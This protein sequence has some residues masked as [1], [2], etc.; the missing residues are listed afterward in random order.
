M[1]NGH[2]FNEIENNLYSDNEEKEEEEFNSNH[3]NNQKKRKMKKDLFGYIIPNDSED[4]EER[5]ESNSNKDDSANISNDNSEKENEYS[6]Y[7]KD[8]DKETSKNPDNNSSDKHNNGYENNY[9]DDNNDLINDSI[10]G[11]KF[12]FNPNNQIPESPRFLKIITNNNN[13]NNNN[14]INNQNNNNMHNSINKDNQFKKKDD[15]EGRNNTTEDIDEILKKL[16]ISKPIVDDYNTNKKE[17]KNKESLKKEQIKTGKENNNNSIKKEI[18][19][20]KMD[21]KLRDISIHILNEYG[22]AGDS[23]I[24]LTEN[25]INTY[26]NM[27]KISSN[28]N[29]ITIKNN[30]DIFTKKK[31]SNKDS[32]KEYNKI[33]HS[34]NV[35]YKSPKNI[36]KN[37]FTENRITFTSNKKTIFKK[38]NNI[39]NYC[40]TNT[41]RK[42]RIKITP[43]L[44]RITRNLYTPK[45]CQK[46]HIDNY[47]FSPKINSKSQEI[48]NKKI[49]N[50]RPNT[51]IGD[52]LYAEAY[53]KRQ[54]QKLQL[55]MKEKNEK[56]NKM[57]MNKSTYN[58]AFIRIKKKI[59]NT[60]KKYSKN[61]KLSIVGFTQCLFDL[62]IITELIKKKDNKENVNDDLDIVKLQA[63][64][65][66]IKVNDK[67]KFNEVE[68]L[69]QLWFKINPSNNNYINSQLLSELLKILFSSNNKVNELMN[70]I[71]ALFKKSGIYINN[72]C[73]VVEYDKNNILYTSPLTNKIYNKN[74]FWSLTKIIKLFINIM[75]NIKA[76]KFNDYNKSKKYNEI[77]ENRDKDL[78]FKPELSNKKS[79]Y[80]YNKNNY[81]LSPK[82]KGDTKKR[83]NDFNDICEKLM[84]EKDIHTS[85]EKIRE[86]KPAKQLK[87]IKIC[88]NIPKINKSNSPNKNFNKK[89]KT[90][91]NDSDEFR[92]LIKSKSNINVNKPVYERSYNKRKKNNDHYNNTIKGIKY[93]GNDEIFN[94]SY[95]NLEKNKKLKQNDEY[96]KKNIDALKKKEF[97]K[98]FKEEKFYNNYNKNKKMNIKQ[99]NISKLKEQ[100]TPPKIKEKINKNEFINNIENENIFEDIF[101]TVNIKIPNGSSKPLKIYDKNYNDT[102]GYVNNF[103]RIY[104]INDEY[105]KIIFKKVMQYKNSFFNSRNKIENNK[106]GFVMNEDFDTIANTYNDSNPSNNSN[107]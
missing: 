75:Q 58:M 49:K 18:Y 26:T 53:M 10:G 12:S 85:L 61:G 23:Q 32:K 19:N 25:N 80:D 100:K 28:K 4:D 103:C 69:E 34:R 101:I 73:D 66:S 84:C 29:D 47:S 9:N 54:K 81:I 96:I 104:H 21:N 91:N 90:I 42:R 105:K 31:I 70:Y 24:S 107:P 92:F 102:L 16:R 87:I 71:E 38:E 1:S 5:E 33:P 2:N 17:I 14:E 106:D 27:G 52:I 88:T 82:N 39:T 83:K 57:K 7:Q 74:E 41:N 93:I 45:R 59:D 99:V 94:E 37:N 65:K 63:I 68:L 67:K 6:R 97:E 15:D 50:K 48:Y 40:Y 3:N 46:K 35:Q 64:I 76:Y 98:Q 86:M 60:I 51:P 13:I 22:K 8:N 43:D 30:N 20:K 44:D 89:N 79:K 55:L 77:I 72:D 95:S 62:N 78:M 56:E 36:I 11:E